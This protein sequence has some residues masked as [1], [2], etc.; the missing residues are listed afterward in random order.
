[1]WI[2][3]GG[4]ALIIVW[5]FFFIWKYDQRLSILE[6]QIILLFEKRTQLI[7]ALYEIT[8]PYLT[9]HDEVFWEI[10]AL[11]KKEFHQY[12]EK[13][14]LK[15]QNEKLIHHELNFIFQVANKH[16]KIQKD[17]RFLLI[18][19]LFLEN[20][21]AIWKKIGTYKKIILLF[22]RYVTIKNLT[23]IWILIPIEKKIEI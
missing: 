20:S 16:P 17:S 23:V 6:K 2:I 12:G 5:F 13:F 19:D 15:I 1:M 14:I 22:N 8:K 11:R 21:Y 9:K 10:L 7:P 4:I 18:R 3:L